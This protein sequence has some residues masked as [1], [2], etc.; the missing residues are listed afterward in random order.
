MQSEKRVVI[1]R[2]FWETG[3]RDTIG[4]HDNKLSFSL[5][6]CLFRYD[7]ELWGWIVTICGVRVHHKRAYGGRF[8]R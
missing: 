2:L 7:P 3:T 4:W 6:P 5:K 8:P 1:S